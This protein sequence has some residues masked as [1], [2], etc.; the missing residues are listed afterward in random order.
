MCMAYVQRKEEV[1]L[2]TRSRATMKKASC[3]IGPHQPTLNLPLK[4]KYLKDILKK[5]GTKDAKPIKTPMSTNGHLDLDEKWQKCGSKGI[6]L[7]DWI[8]ILPFMYLDLISCLVCVCVLAF[9]RYLRN[10][11]WLPLR[12]SFSILF[13]LL[14]LACDI[15]RVVPNHASISDSNYVGCKVDH[16]SIIGSSQFLGQSLVF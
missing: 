6:P 1:P 13:I 5:F 12:E 4:P 7:H 16:K 8:L 11:I 14:I 9:K 3:P 10:V 15:L 2:N